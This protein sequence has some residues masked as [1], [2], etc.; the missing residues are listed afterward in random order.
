[1]DMTIL[2]TETW[3][4]GLLDATNPRALVN[5]APEVLRAYIQ[6]IPRDLFVYTEAQLEKVALP[7]FTS[8]CLR[9]QF[10]QEY[11]RAQDKN[12]DMVFGN[13]IKGVTHRAYFLHLAKERPEEF[14]WICVPPRAYD[15]TQRQIMDESLERM[16]DVLKMTMI[17]ETVTEKVDANGNVTKT[18]TRKINAAAL[19]E[20]RKTSEMLQNRVIGS[21]TAKV[22]H[23][24][25]I[26][27]G[28]Q[29]SGEVPG[30]ISIDAMSDIN[31]A[32]KSM[33]A[34]SDEIEADVVEGETLEE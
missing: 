14:A 4:P 23:K 15:V 27:G 3:D 11:V 24:H 2:D 10:W 33:D 34:P 21:L 26:E 1:M 25:M 31:N 5:I 19:A 9:I 22:D 6:A 29:A 7:D 17:D 12:I 32:L 13:I 30:I 28:K 20:I 18:T 16:R 8:K